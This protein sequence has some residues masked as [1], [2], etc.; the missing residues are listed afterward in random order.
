MAVT[1][2]CELEACK[3]NFHKQ[4][5]RADAPATTN[6]VKRTVRNRIKKIFEYLGESQQGNFRDTLA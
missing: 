5:V 3:K 4:D 1:V 2:S 6:E